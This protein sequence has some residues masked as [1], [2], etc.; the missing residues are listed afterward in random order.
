[1]IDAVCVVPG[2]P[3]PSYAEGYSHRDNDFYA[4]WEPISRDPDRFAAWM[5]RHVLD[6]ADH[7]EYV[8]SLARESAGV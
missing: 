6:T 5:Q 3:H 2:G 4:A 1:V 7:G 8:A